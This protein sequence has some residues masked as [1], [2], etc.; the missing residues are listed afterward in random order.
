MEAITRT[1][2]ERKRGSGIMGIVNKYNPYE[3]KKVMEGVPDYTIR[4]DTLYRDTPVEV[5]EDGVRVCKTEEV[6]TKEAFI[7]CYK[8]WIIGDDGK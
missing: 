2:Q 1:I 6:I 3:P 4:K 8:A 5:Y 7:K